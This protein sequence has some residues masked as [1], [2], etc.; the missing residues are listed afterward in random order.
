MVFSAGLRLIEC[1]RLRIQDIDFAR[2]EI[3][4]RDGKGARVYSRVYSCW[5][6]GP[7]CSL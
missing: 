1:L 5:Q 7:C 2:N 6:R 4:V 3:M